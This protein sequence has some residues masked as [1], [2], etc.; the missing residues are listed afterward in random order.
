MINFK[1]KSQHILKLLRSNVCKSLLFWYVGIKLS[2]TKCW[3]SV[4]TSD[5]FTVFT[6]NFDV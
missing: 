6:T 5:K 3:F 2:S 4:N 1:M